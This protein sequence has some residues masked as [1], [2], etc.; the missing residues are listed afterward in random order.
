MKRVIAV[1][2]NC[3]HGFSVEEAIDGISRAGFHYVEMT[4]TKGWTEHVFPDMSL[5]YLA[6]VKEKCEEKGLEIIAMSGHCN[7]MDRERIQDF[8][9][10][11]KLANFLGCKYIVSSIGEAHLKNNVVLSEEETAERLREL[12]PFLEKYR[13]LLV[14]EVH[15]KE[16]GTGKS[17]KRILERVQSPLVQMTYDTGN[18]VFYGRTDVEADVQAC[19]D[20]IA[21]MHLKDKAGVA[22][23]WNFPA[24]GKGD[25]RFPEILRILEERQNDCPFSIEIEFTPKGPENLEEVNRAVEESYRYLKSIGMEM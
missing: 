19:V 10:N 23:E 14:L 6:S 5:S 1:N 13:L 11:M 17:I 22:D 4:A 2:S 16:H 24:L 21:Y 9:E 18:A 8:I 7:L 20:R 15:G 12:L 3:Y 25:I